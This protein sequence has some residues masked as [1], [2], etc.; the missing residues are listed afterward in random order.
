MKRKPIKNV[1][2]DQRAFSKTARKV[3]IKNVLPAP[4]R[5][6]IRL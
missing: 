1:R 3:N 2:R 5:G 4:R 6:G